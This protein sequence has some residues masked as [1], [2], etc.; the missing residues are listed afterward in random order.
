MLPTQK[1]SDILE[2]FFQKYGYDRKILEHKAMFL[3]SDVVGEK[4]ALHAQPSS[5]SDGKVLVVVGDSVRLTELNLQ[6]L[7][8]IDQLNGKLGFNV[9]KDIEFKL[10]NVPEPKQF[11]HL[12][13]DKITDDANLDDIELEGEMLERIEQVVANVENKELK[14]ILTRFFT[15]HAKLSKLKD[16]V[17]W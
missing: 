14:D 7:K 13:T 3:W 2:T 4:F 8:L 17:V 15:S 11:S 9:I 12:D 16:W 6:K 5:I 1:L 10:G